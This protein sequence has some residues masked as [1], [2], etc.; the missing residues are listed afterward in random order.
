[1]NDMN[2]TIQINKR[3]KVIATYADIGDVSGSCMPCKMKY[4]GQDITFTE[5]ALRHPTV[6]GKRMIHV[7]HMSDGANGYRLEFDAE[8]LAWTLVSMIPEAP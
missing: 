6:Q 8:R 7:F 2:P 5:L 3:V 4:N 1:M